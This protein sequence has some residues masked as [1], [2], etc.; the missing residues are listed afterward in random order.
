[1]ARSQAVTKKEEK[2]G[3]PAAFLD[4]MEADAGAGTGEITTSDLAIPFLRP[5]QK[6]SPCLSKRD[7]DYIEGASEGDIMNTVTGEVWGPEE[8]VMVIPCDFKFK[9]LEWWPRDSKQGSGLV[10]SY[11]REDELPIHEKDEKNK[12]IT[13]TG[14]L[15]EDTAEHYVL[16][17]NPDGTCEEAL[18]SM[19]STQL[20]TSRKW[21]SMMK[22][23]TIIGPN[24]PIK[25]PSFAYMYC[26]K[27]AIQSNDHGEW[28]QWSVADAGQITDINLYRA[29]KTFNQSVSSGTVIVKHSQEESDT[30][31]M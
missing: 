16:V 24:G 25:A 9:I 12:T 7:P 14:T 2:G 11:T 26:L 20:R 1:M 3:L 5:I 17:V 28:A 6:M 10:N 30:T 23:K 4:E 31:V 15:L 22:K 21:N 18:I 29:G 27:T 8:G 19:S 13:S